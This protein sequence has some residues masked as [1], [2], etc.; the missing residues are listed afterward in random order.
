[1]KIDH[2]SMIFGVGND[3]ESHC[4]VKYTIVLAYFTNV[5]MLRRFALDNCLF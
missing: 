5:I 2:L 1:M 3:V 4:N